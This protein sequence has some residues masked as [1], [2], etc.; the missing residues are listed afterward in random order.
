MSA[1]VLGFQEV[2][3]NSTAVVGGKGANLGELSRIEG[4]RVPDGF[5]IST[6]AFTRIVGEMPSLDEL[7]ERLAGLKAGARD[8]VSEVSREIRRAI[9]GVDI[10][11]DIHVAIARGLSRFDESEAFAVR[12]SATAED[13]PTAS[14][15]G[16]HDTYLNVIGEPEILKRISQCWASPSPRPSPTTGR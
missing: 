3:R 9:E 11:E 10:P 2:D 16:Q 12:S 14:F 13:L 6:G 8:E 5:C 4:L 7:L 1:Y 15:A